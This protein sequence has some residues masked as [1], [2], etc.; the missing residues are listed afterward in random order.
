MLPKSVIS[1][2]MLS[3]FP[4]GGAMYHRASPP[5]PEYSISLVCA[6]VVFGLIL[7]IALTGVVLPTIVQTVV[8]AI[9]RTVTGA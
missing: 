3:G 8:P 7:G 2:P 6:A 5:A 4:M 1:R 9:L